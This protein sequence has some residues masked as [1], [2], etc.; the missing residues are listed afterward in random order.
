MTGLKITWAYLTKYFFLVTLVV[1]FGIGI[2]LMFVSGKSSA[3]DWQKKI[4]DLQKKHEEEVNQIRAEEEKKNKELID[5]YEKT[6]QD[7][8]RQYDEKQKQLEDDKKQE[9]QDIIVQY[10]KDP[11]KVSQELSDLLPGIDVKLP[12]DFQ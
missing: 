4:D 1:G 5:H 8:Q 11:V 2:L 6:M 3:A 10:G 9:I 7:I 12:E